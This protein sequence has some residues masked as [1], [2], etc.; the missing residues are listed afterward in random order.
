MNDAVISPPAL[1]TTLAVDATE[2]LERFRFALEHELLVQA[3]W[4][5]ER[6]GRQ[7]ACALGVLGPE[8]SRPADCPASVMPKWLAVM[9]PNFFDAM[10]YEAATAWGLAFYEQL[11]RLK[12][13]VPFSVV[14]D[15]QA[16]CV[17]EFW[18]ASLKKRKFT[19][20][21]LAEKLARVEA[22]RALHVLHLGGGAAPKAAWREALRP[23]YAYAYADAYAY[24]YADADAD[25]YADAARTPLKAGETK[26]DLRQRRRAE[27]IQLMADGL[28]AAMA[29][30]G[31]VE[32]AA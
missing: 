15:W 1:P 22:A 27:N 32:S 5:V 31:A 6:D 21:Q 20:A 9:V 29:R 28:V 13:Q 7:L 17:L 8:V 25:A 12:G 11:A 2:A 3:N 10:P 24:A 30:V 14:Y 23:L 16:H 18:A 4:H 19:E 26:A